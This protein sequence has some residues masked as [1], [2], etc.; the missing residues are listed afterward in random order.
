MH[1][2]P[3]PLLRGWG[4]FR[5]R[6]WTTKLMKTFKHTVDGESIP[7]YYPEYSDDLDEFWVFMRKGSRILALDTETTGL[8][9][10]SAGFACRLVQ[11]GDATEAWVL[12]ADRW[13]DEIQR[14][15]ADPGQRW[16]CHNAPFDLLVLDVTGLASLADLGPRVFDTFILSHLCDPRTEADGGAGLGLKALSTVYVDPTAADTSKD[17]YEV[18]H[19]EYKATKETGWALIDIDHPLYVTYAGLDVIY[20]SR[21]FRELTILIR[22]EGMSD[23]AKFE[24]RVQ[25]LTTAQQRRGLLVDVEYTRAQGVDLAAEAEHFAEVAARYGVA[26]VNSTKQVTAALLGMG[27]VWDEV[28]R[29]GLPAVGKEVLLPM[30]DLNPQWEALTVRTANPLADAVLRSKRAQKWGNTYVGAF[31]NDR[32]SDDR[33]HPFIRSLAARTARMSVA[34]PPLQQLPSGD[35]TIRRCIIADRGQTIIAADY[36]AVEMRVLA[37]LAGVSRMKTLIAEG[38][39]LHTETARLVYSAEEWDA[40]DGPARKR[41]RGLMKTVGFGKVYGGGLKGLARQSGLSVDAV[42]PALEGYDRAYPEITRWGQSL[43]RSAASKG[44]AVY[45]PIGRRLPLDRERAYAATNYVVQSTARDVL[46]QALCRIDDAGMSEFVLLPVHDEL[47]CQAPT[48]DAADVVKEI[49]RLMETT[50]NGVFIA[51]D[52]QVYGPSWGH[53]YGA[54]V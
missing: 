10:F 25:L 40:A 12:D 38:A 54:T 7:I 21:L 13:R 30:A 36:A 1:P 39:D 31:L 49:G 37:A 20:T 32:D 26:N 52:P 23:L 3:P 19:K 48:A 27:E 44:N 4:P 15:L 28:T 35:W 22:R 6:E 50:I 11:I 34:N 14:A 33:I 46:A 47:V 16:V 53:G 8:R 41:M 2:A 17:L 9:I 45:T 18:F 24:H 5:L 42:R 43:Q 51:S 29:T